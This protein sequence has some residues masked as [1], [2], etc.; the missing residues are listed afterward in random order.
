MPLLPVTMFMAPV[1]PFLDPN[2]CRRSTRAR[3]LVPLI[4]AAMLGE[5][6]LGNTKI[7]ARPA[8]A[9]DWRAEAEARGAVVLKQRSLN[10]NAG[11]A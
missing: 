10:R 3:K 9:P 4:N 8:A 11:G 5:D 6:R 7:A 1:R 2:D